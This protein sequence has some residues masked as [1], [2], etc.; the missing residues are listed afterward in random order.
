MATYRLLAVLLAGVI[1]LGITPA[2]AIETESFGFDVIEATGD[3]RLHVLI[4]AG[5]QSTAELK[6]WNKQQAELRL[7]FGV[8]PA[9]VDDAGNPVLGGDDEPVAWVKVEP[10]ALT[11]APGEEQRVKIVVRAPRKLDGDTKTVAVLATPAHEADVPPAVL[12]RL[13]ITTYLEPDEESLI[14]SL[15]I[16]P[17][18]AAL[19]LIIVGVL[20]A[21]KALRR[22]PAVASDE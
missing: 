15:G 10:A 2:G 17:W 16:A 7:D 11:L 13:A 6:V 9:R 18:I 21:R 19:I 1:L 14:A 22:G 20:V 5:E 12:Q 8:S 4:K 3:R